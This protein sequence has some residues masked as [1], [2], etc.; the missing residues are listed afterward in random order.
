MFKEDLLENEMDE[1]VPVIDHERYKIVAKK[2]KFE[3][4]GSQNDFRSKKSLR[5]SSD[6]IE[7][8]ILNFNT[9]SVE[10]LKEL[11]KVFYDPTQ[12]TITRISSPKSDYSRIEEKIGLEYERCRKSP[13]EHIGFMEL[14]FINRVVSQPAEI[15]ERYNEHMV[16]ESHTTMLRSEAYFVSKGVMHSEIKGTRKSNYIGFGLHST[17]DLTLK[18]LKAPLA[19]FTAIGPEIGSRTDYYSMTQDTKLLNNQRRIINGNSQEFWSESVNVTFEADL[20]KCVVIQPRFV[21]GDVPVKQSYHGMGSGTSIVD[22]FKEED[23][24]PL[25]TS[26][27]RVIVCLDY[28]RVEQINDE[29]YF[30]RILPATNTSVGDYSMPANQVVTTLRGHRAFEE[31]R[32]KDLDNDKKILI[33]KGTKEEVV[34]RYNNF[35]KDQGK[36]IRYKTRLGQGYPGL[37]E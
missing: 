23:S 18:A 24:R 1:V 32:S 19:L 14:R 22:W 27:K 6:S 37:I 29:W 9:T 31:F 16:T 3:V 11:C 25:V 36:A 20:K 13:V 7:D 17:G 26:N 30:V 4:F 35:I 21:K 10:T 8:M 12:K 2:V 33:Q 15:T 5:V 34:K 28:N